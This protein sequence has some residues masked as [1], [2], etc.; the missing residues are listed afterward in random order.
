MYATPTRHSSL[1]DIWDSQDSLV[2]VLF[3]CSGHQY[4]LLCSDISPGSTSHVCMPLPLSVISTFCLIVLRNFII[5]S[6]G[7]FK[8]Y[9]IIPSYWNPQL[10]MSAKPFFLLKKFSLY[11]SYPCAQRLFQ[12][13]IYW[14]PFSTIL[15][16]PAPTHLSHTVI[17]PLCFNKLNVGL[18]SFRNTSR[19]GYSE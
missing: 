7:A 3:I 9:R 13:N 12:T 18:I 10:I 1:C 6:L 11:I 2:L 16:Y 15:H 4:S 19:W 8:H 5:R 14:S 17:R